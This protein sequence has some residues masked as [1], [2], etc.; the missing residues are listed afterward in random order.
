MGIKRGNFES[1]GLG[2][3]AQGVNPN[4]HHHASV[5]GGLGALASGMRAYAAGWD[6][7][8]DGLRA[9]GD[10]FTDFGKKA[11]D[12]DAQQ[13]ENERMAGEAAAEFEKGIENGLT[14]NDADYW[15]LH[16]EMVR[17]RYRA[18]HQSLFGVYSSPQ[19]TQE[20]KRNDDGKWEMSEM[21][22]ERKSKRR[23]ALGISEDDEKM[24]YGFGGIFSWDGEED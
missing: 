23:M 14:E 5:A 12:A 9:W 4:Y 24:S 7:I 11:V 17:W 6:A 16:D 21:S 22:D 1:V 8:A 10:L 19:P 20:W 18:D 2:A 13:K 15:R 3:L